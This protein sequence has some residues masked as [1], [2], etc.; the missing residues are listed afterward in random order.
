MDHQSECQLWENGADIHTYYSLALSL[1]FVVQSFCDIFWVLYKESDDFWCKCEMMGNGWP[2][3]KHT[4]S[5]KAYK[6]LLYYVHE[7]FSILTSPNLA[8]QHGI[9]GPPPPPPPARC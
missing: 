4:K 8:L 6:T 3:R 2:L 7:L 1:L 5:N 9:A